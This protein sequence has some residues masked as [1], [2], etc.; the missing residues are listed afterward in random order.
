LLEAMASRL[1]VVGTYEDNNELKGLIKVER[2]TDQIVEAVSKLI[3]P[4]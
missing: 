2:N 3:S 1:P 4:I